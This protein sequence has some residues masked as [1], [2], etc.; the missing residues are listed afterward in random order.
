[1]LHFSCRLGKMQG[2]LSA[3][4]SVICD[5]AVLADGHTYHS[6]LNMVDL[7]G[8]ERSSKT[9]TEGAVAKEAL[10][11]NK[12]LS[13]LE[14]VHWQDRASSFLEIWNGTILEKGIA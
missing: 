1:M 6:K 11:I 3:E 10:Y 9:G 2:L 4:R 7:A 12:S 14:Q 13:F 8:S 5:A